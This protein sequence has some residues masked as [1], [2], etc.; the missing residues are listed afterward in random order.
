MAQKICDVR[1]DARLVHGQTA[2]FCKGKYSFTRILCIDDATAANTMQKS[3]LKLACPAATKL[4]VLGTEKAATNLLNEKY[5]DDVTFIIVKTPGVLV[6]LWNKGYR[7]EH[8]VVG[9]M[10]KITGV[11]TTQVSKSVHVTARDAADFHALAD[12]GVKIDLQPVPADA[13]EDFMALLTKA[14]L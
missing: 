14:G 12:L 9:N 6:E 1:I 11:E 13:P 5:K 3:L 8:V 7:M 10:P 2:T 4:S